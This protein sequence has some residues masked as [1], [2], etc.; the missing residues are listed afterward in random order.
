MEN[1][2]VR[3]RH[4]PHVD[5]DGKPYFVTGCL[6]GSISHAG[7]SSIRRRRDTLDAQPTPVGLS[8]RQ[9]QVNKNKL[10][11]KF[12]DDLLDGR[13]PVEHLRDERVARQVIQAL[14]H[15][16]EVRY[17]LFAFVVMP[18]HHHWLFLPT[19]T[20]SVEFAARRDAKTHLKTPRMAICHSIQSYTA[21][22]CNRILNQ[23]G[24]FWQNETYD[25]FARDEHELLRIIDYIENNP[26]KAGLVE[27]PEAW[28]HSSASLRDRLGITAG[29]AIPR[30][31]Y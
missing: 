7:L 19:E 17:H 24:D 22:M 26:V 20:Y 13:C 18:S 2:S 27:R 14:L 25:H 15:F 23:K 6:K 5:V 30:I 21:T 28:K 29:Q 3:R 16:A 11:F 1:W 8:V 10:L 4:L 9:W 31:D 12:I